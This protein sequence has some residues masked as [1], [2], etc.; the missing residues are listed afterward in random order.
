MEEAMLIEFFMQ[1][2]KLFLEWSAPMKR[3]RVNRFK[4]ILS[5][6]AETM[7]KDQCM[8]QLLRL[9]ETTVDDIS[10]HLS[11]ELRKTKELIFMPSKVSTKQAD[12]MTTKA[13]VLDLISAWF[14]EYNPKSSLKLV[15]YTIKVYIMNNDN[16][17]SALDTSLVF[18]V[19]N[20]IC[21]RLSM[22]GKDVVRISDIIAVLN[23]G[24]I[25][26]LEGDHPEGLNVVLTLAQ[27]A[28]EQMCNTVGYTYANW[29]ETTFVNA[30]TSIL[31]KR[32]G[33]I[34]MNV[35]H[36][37]IPYEIP[38]VLQ[39][40]GR[41]LQHC[42]TLNNANNYVSAVKRRLLEL[43]VDSSFRNYPQAL[44]LP[45]QSTLLSVEDE[46]GEVIQQFKK[47]NA[48][49]QSLLSS[50][51]FKRQWFNNTFVPMLL[52]WSGPDIVS[53][54]ALIEALRQAKKIR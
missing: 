32:M 54:D 31:N 48:I 34:F 15:D 38:S 45:I 28:F 33:T 7:R 20:A 26:L 42:T 19:F 39:I 52:S 14:Y 36:Q 27:T 11:R 3:E 16:K 23:D 29:F 47:R 9:R 53:R 13:L 22:E 24:V 41:A 49:P 37:S 10:R 40:H 35:L 43:G 6:Y 21:K 46:V 1:D 25:K 51:V 12:T 8:T 44:K 5:N 18:H 50:S 2:G 30:N 17:Q 4:Y